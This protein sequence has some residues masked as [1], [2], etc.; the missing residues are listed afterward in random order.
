[1]ER[2]EETRQNEA[3]TWYVGLGRASKR[4]YLMYDAFHG[5]IDHLPGN[6]ALQAAASAE[7]QVSEAMTD[8]G[9]NDR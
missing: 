5:A 3:R 1:M 7:L 2:S 6:L 9:A 8:G 4:L